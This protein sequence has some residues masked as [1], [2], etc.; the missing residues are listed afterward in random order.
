MNLFDQITVSGTG[1]TYPALAGFE[2][3]T[4]RMYRS[5]ER[6]LPH[7]GGSIEMAVRHAIHEQLSA[8][9]GLASLRTQTS[10]NV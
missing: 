9:Q 4:E 6:F 5:A 10:A 8:H 3:D 7:C 2:L 1:V